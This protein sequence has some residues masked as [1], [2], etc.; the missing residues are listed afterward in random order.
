M[1]R[2]LISRPIAV[3]MVFIAILTL[4][5]VSYRMLPVSLMPGIDIPVIT[6]Q[7]TYPK[8]SARELENAIVKNLRTQ[9]KQVQHLNDIT[10]HTRDG[11]SII[12]LAFD[13]GTQ[14][15]YAFI[16]VNEKIDAS[17]NYLPRDMERPRVIRASATDLPIFY[18][19]VTLKSDSSLKGDINKIS[20]DKFIE[21]S[22]FC[23]TV[24]R[25]RM[26]QLPEVAM[27]DMSGTT[28]PEIIIIP[29][30]RKIE[31]LGITNQQIQQAIEQN[32]VIPGNILVRDGYYQY[33]IRFDSYLK[34][35]VDIGN[36]Y[37]KTESK[38]LRLKEIAE[39]KIQQQAVRGVFTTGGKQAITMA[40]IQQS[41]AQMAALKKELNKLIGSFERDYPFLMFETAQDQSQ[42]LDYSISNL[43]QDLL[44]GSLMAFLVLFLFLNDLR[45][46]VLIGITVPVSLIISLLFFKIF[47][48]SI[49]IISLSGLALGIGMIIDCSIIVIENILHNRTLGLSLKEACIRGTNQVIRPMLSS[50]LSTSAVFMPLIF[51]G[52]MAGALFY[53]E[54]LSVTFGN[55]A[56][57][58]VA[59]TLLPVLFALLYK[60]KSALGDH[61]NKDSNAKKFLK[62]V[63]VL[64]GKLSVGNIIE[65]QYEKALDW[66]FGHQVIVTTLFLVFLLLN[67]IL[68][69]V[70][71]KEVMPGYEQTDL[72]A[73]IAWNENIHLDENQRRTEELLDPF[74]EMIKQSN[75]RIGEQQFL[76]DQTREL[77]YFETEIYLKAAD[78]YSINFIKDS[79]QSILLAKFPASKVTFRTPENIFERIFSNNEPPLVAKVSVNNG[80]KTLPDSVIA[81]VNA[82]DSKVKAVIPNQL[83]FNEYLAVS[84]NQEKLLL[85]G[86]SYDA[87]YQ[88]IKTAFNE[89][90]F[91]MLRSYQRYMPIVLG[92]SS[93]SISEVLAGK[94]IRNNSGEE[95]PVT[96]FLDIER[97]RDL[98]YITAGQQGEYLPLNYF[99]TGNETEQYKNTITTLVR[100]NGFPDVQFTGSLVSSEKMIGKL[101]IILLIS[102]LLLYFILAAQFE[103]LLQPL[104][105]LLELPVDIAGALLLLYVFGSSLNLMSGIGIIIMTGVIINDSILKVDTI[106]QLRRDGVPL[107]DAIKQ[108]G[109]LRLG[110]IL[111]TASTAILAVIPFFFGNDIG[112]ALQQPLSLALIGGMVVGTLVSLFFVPLVYWWIYRKQESGNVSNH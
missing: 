78:A 43:K 37:I 5:I 84:I 9:L 13:Y 69:N 67:F 15:D 34:S 7:V 6:V 111:M 92:E 56:S 104:I 35:P 14:V 77:D 19:N 48:I 54:A 8:S 44:M 65:K 57:F 51:I 80:G 21:L 112:S 22:E 27:V 53:D 60:K 30:K 83:Q 75:C 18:L 107:M 61:D 95:V 58:I 41:D 33:H 49:N 109:V 73:D 103:S 42:L 46:P 102:L 90:Q 3:I 63:R 97:N 86:V 2:F 23:K 108:G 31:S 32:N 10:S 20:D 64:A 93:Q 100:E 29:D 71:K 74:Q 110:S 38:I 17:M 26:E 62:K 98:K 28:S 82:T 99:I 72:I 66:T 16:E 39:I 12:K 106:N 94:K 105:V 52:G 25:P 45:A 68:F 70:V 59:I 1:V 81:F 88:S 91:A 79:I 24:I 11:K 85:Y 40:V 4:G 96:V 76:L 87:V 36:I 55:A 47:G 89:N 101:S 50:T